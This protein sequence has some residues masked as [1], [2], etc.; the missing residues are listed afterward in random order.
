M[1]LQGQEIE[2][3]KDEIFPLLE[4]ESKISNKTNFLPCASFDLRMSRSG[5]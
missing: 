2:E 1:D 4:Y 5:Y 3:E